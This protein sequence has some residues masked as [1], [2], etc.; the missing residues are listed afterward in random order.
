MRYERDH[1]AG[2]HRRALAGAA[3]AGIAPGV[4]RGASAGARLPDEGGDAGFPGAEVVD[5]PGLGVV[6]L[7][8]RFRARRED[9]P[10]LRHYTDT[11]WP[12]SPVW[13]AAG[14]FVDWAE[15]ESRATV[16]LSEGSG[17]LSRR[18][19]EFQ[20]P[21]NSSTLDR[22]GRR[23]VFRGRARDV[24]RFEADDS[25]TVLA[26]QGEDGGFNGPNHGVVHPGDGSIWFP[27]P[28]YGSVGFYCGA[29]VPPIPI[30]PAI[31]RIDGVTGRV[32]KVADE[33]SF[34]WALCF[35]PDCTKL[36][37]LSDGI[38]QW[39]V[40][41]AR[42]R[43]GRLLVRPAE[44]PGTSALQA[45]RCDTDGNLWAARCWSAGMKVDDGGTVVFAPDGEPIGLVQ[46]PEI[47]TNLCFGGT[48]RN[49]LFV[50]GVESLYSV[51]VE[52]NGAHFC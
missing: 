3:M 38:W 39:D 16:R 21:W 6:A 4:V 37:T 29:D 33:A 42:L 19:F 7:S 41:G 23:I 11:G 49:R 17:A 50:T 51:F 22:E 15:L 13:H 46:L 2:L 30:P 28:G 5:R 36:Y 40:D 8:P 27:D 52:A 34:P 44:Y 48:R 12:D 20:D 32:T 47:C 26:R 25:V 10:L 18:T 35:N 31:W 24:V 9:A 1:R 14:R 43:N 45:I